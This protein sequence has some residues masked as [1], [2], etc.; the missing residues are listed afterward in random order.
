MPQSPARRLTIL[1]ARLSSPD[2]PDHRSVS[3]LRVSGGIGSQFQPASRARDLID[4]WT[5]R[6]SAVKSDSFSIAGI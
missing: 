2:K 6:F 1:A 4:P 5:Q 3:Q